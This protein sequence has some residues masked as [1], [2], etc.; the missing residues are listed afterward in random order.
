MAALNNR[1]AVVT[2]AGRGIG[3]AIAERL[4]GL[5]APVTLLARTHTE[6][7]A[8]AA[9]IGARGGRALAVATDVT[10]AKSV[11]AALAAA[12]ERHGPTRIL[13]NNAG[14]PGP[15]GPIGVLDP[16]EWWASQQLHQFAPLLLMSGIIR[17]MQAAGGGRIINIVSSAAT[18]P[19]AHLSA[20]A[21]GKCAALR[22]TETVDLEQRAHGIRAFALQPGTIVTDMA[23]STLASPEAAQWIPDGI[24]MLQARTAAESAADLERCTAVVAALAEGQYDILAGRYLDISWDL[25]ERARLAGAA[26][27]E[28]GT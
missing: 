2:G 26:A 16:Q 18:L 10:D 11:A 24:A 6:I 17:G 20:Y 1:P 27:A 25:D 14:I 21:V 28:A 15:Y 13:V 7:E 12:R 9:A 22:L 3:R 19:I 8:V 23:R 4:A 5:G